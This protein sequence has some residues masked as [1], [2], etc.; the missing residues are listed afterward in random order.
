MNSTGRVAR[1]AVCAI[2]GAWDPGGRVMGRIYCA[3]ARTEGGVD[4]VRGVCT[5]TFTI[6]VSV[7]G[8][9][10]GTPIASAAW[11]TAAK[12]AGGPASCAK[13]IGL[14]PRGPVICAAI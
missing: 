9:K 13:R 1:R 10:T 6:N 8:A 2:A 14:T 3:F 7:Y 4:A 11:Q 5:G 12:S